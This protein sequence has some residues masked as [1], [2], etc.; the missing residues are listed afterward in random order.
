MKIG[1][2]EV[3]NRLAVK[4]LNFSESTSLLKSESTVW[5]STSKSLSFH[6]S[7]V[8]EVCLMKRIIFDQSKHL[9]H[10]SSWRLKRNWKIISKNNSPF[11]TKART[12]QITNLTGLKKQFAWILMA[13]VRP[14]PELMMHYYHKTLFLM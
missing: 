8:I 6:S 7:K 12:K 3:K 10:F 11:T 13:S 2:L 9:P 5:K 1:R 4:R 14:T